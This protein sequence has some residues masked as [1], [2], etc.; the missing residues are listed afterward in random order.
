[1]DAKT[2][3]TSLQSGGQI[4]NIAN[5]YGQTYYWHRFYAVSP[6]DPTPVPAVQR[7]AQ[8]LDYG[9]YLQD[10]WRLPWGLTVN[11]GLRWDGE[12]TRN[13]LGETVFRFR[14]EWQPRLG[15][16][17]DPWKDGKTKVSVFGGRF[18][19]ALPTMA[20]AFEF[21]R[22]PN[23]LTFN[24]DPVSVVQDPSV[25]GHRE[26]ARAG[27]AGPRMPWMPASRRRRRM[28]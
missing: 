28:S 20:A 22:S 18:S 15:V 3:A 23:F 21:A 7:R 5:D 13:Y 11:A 17:W 1:M 9:A 10:S 24:F 27:E 16:V 19:H 2:D 6:T 8:T 26:G 12:T 25:L 14:D 4:V